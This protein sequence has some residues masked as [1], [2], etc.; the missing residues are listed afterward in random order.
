M[1]I[2]KVSRNK[3]EVKE[4]E[5][6]VTIEAGRIGRNI[7]VTISDG[8]RTIDLAL[9]RIESEKFIRALRRFGISDVRRVASYVAAMAEVKMI[10]APRAI[11]MEKIED[12][13][14]I[15][16]TVLGVT[17]NVYFHTAEEGWRVYV[18]PEQGGIVK[19]ALN[20]AAPA[21]RTDR[22]FIHYNAADVSY[23]DVFAL[24]DTAKEVKEI[25]KQY[26]VLP[27]EEYYDVVVSWIVLTYMRWAA[28]YSELL[29]IRKPGFGSGGSTLLKTLRLLAARPLR[30]I[31]NTSAA[32]FYRVV[33][34]TMPTIALDEIR[35][36]EADAERL[37]EL[38]LLA[39]SAFDKENVV[40]RVEDVEEVT[41]F[42]TFANVAVVDSTDK[43]TTH[44]SERRAWTVV[45][46]A[47][48]PQRNYDMDE[49]LKAT[50]R[51]R[52]RLYSAGIALPTAFEDI[53]RRNAAV[54]G[55]GALQG[56][57][58]ALKSKELD[59][60]IFE[61]ALAAVS[62][63]LAYARETAVLTDPKRAVA[64]II[65]KIIEDARRELEMAANSNNPADVLTIAAPEDQD[66]RCGIIYLEKLIREIRRRAME[67]VQVDTRKLDNVYYTSSEVRYW[68]RINK[69]IEMYIKPAKVKAI[70][71]ELGVNIELDEGRHYV[72][73][74]CRQT[75]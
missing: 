16:G 9:K 38:K 15:S 66:Y 20:V 4:G 29:I 62:Q 44:S 35:E 11:F 31:V 18:Y 23:D 34:F 58:E 2:N 65:E 54:Q 42:S 52:E 46:K 53:W 5:R 36:D 71:T 24:A 75:A 37:A 57:I 74:V 64:N 25:L 21:W 51:L 28:A 19:E 17:Y 68:F 6:A 39:E 22:L 30:T 61:S 32:A 1:E 41:A 26:V 48:T 7:V 72:V 50:A 10:D 73:R 55:V 49:I 8:E 60:S 33:D 45:V 13:E 43:F 47:S 12:A 3:V 27:R 56:L 59:A 67:V 63:Q 70:L 69:D 40:L 14:L